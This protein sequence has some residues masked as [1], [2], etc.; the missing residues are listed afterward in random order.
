MTTP[1]RSADGGSTWQRVDFG[2][3]VNK[4]RVVMTARGFIAYAIG[5][6]VFNLSAER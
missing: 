3:P 5:V 6:E 4:V 2:T 1:P